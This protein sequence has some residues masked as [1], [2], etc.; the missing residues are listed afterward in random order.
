[1]GKAWEEETVSVGRS[2]RCGSLRDI[3]GM[4]GKMRTWWGRW[5]MYVM[6]RGSGVCDGRAGCEVGGGRWER[7]EQMGC[8][9]ESGRIS[10]ESGCEVTEGTSRDVSGVKWRLGAV[11]NGDCRLWEGRAMAEWGGRAEGDRTDEMTCGRW[12][13]TSEVATG[14]ETVWRAR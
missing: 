14:G 2:M 4:C 13:G 11:L 6:E 9:G 10:N 7:V 8:V 12:Q 1:M 5:G 3:E